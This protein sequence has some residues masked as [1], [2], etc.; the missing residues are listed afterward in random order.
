MKRQYKNYE[1]SLFES[2]QDHEEALAYLN[3]ALQDE[4]QRVF[5]LALKDVLTAQNIDISA[6]AHPSLL[7]KNYLKTLSQQAL[8]Q[9]IS[10][11]VLIYEK[12][13]K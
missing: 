12:L 11:D 4:D 8:K 10:L 3:A 6:F 2:L 5:L 9:G 1:E 7:I 13:R